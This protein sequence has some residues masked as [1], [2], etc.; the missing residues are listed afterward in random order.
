MLP[1]VH[2]MSMMSFAMESISKMMWRENQD[3]REGKLLMSEALAVGVEC[4]Q[5]MY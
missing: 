5:N 3:D 2:M 1:K 4:T